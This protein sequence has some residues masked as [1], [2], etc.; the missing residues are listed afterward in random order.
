MVSHDNNTCIGYYISQ[1][2]GDTGLERVRL[3]LALATWGLTY[4]FKNGASNIILELLAKRLNR[5]S[6][7]EDAM[8]SATPKKKFELLM[9]MNNYFKTQYT[10]LQVW[11]SNYSF[12]TVNIDYQMLRVSELKPKS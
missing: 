8:T 2:I 7:T 6:Q 12:R 10:C 4:N 1:M 3:E 5:S 11:Y 9:V